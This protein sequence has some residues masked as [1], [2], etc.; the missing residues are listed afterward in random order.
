MEVQ[1]CALKMN[2]K[3]WSSEC[4]P[5]FPDRSVSKTSVMVLIS[6]DI[7]L[8]Q[9]DLSAGTRHWHTILSSAWTQ[10]ISANV[11]SSTEPL[12]K[13][14]QRNFNQSTKSFIHENLYENVVCKWRPFCLRPNLINL[15][16]AELRWL[17][18]R[19]S[20]E[21]STPIDVAWPI[22]DQQADPTISISVISNGRS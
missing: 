1:T 8:Q 18:D 20:P 7:Y 16:K 15:Y 3:I 2:L 22:R 6:G 12:G 14:H 13:K 10:S 9:W 5:F 17:D 21:M 19:Y 4:R 11:K